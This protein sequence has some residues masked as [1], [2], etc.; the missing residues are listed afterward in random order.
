[1]S[2]GYNV[3]NTVSGVCTYDVKRIEDDILVQSI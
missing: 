2:H 3:I 1:M